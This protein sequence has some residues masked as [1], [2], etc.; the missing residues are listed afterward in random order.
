M[1]PPIGSTTVDPPLGSRTRVNP[2][3]GPRAYRRNDE[4]YFFGRSEEVDELT[5]LVLSSSATLLYAPSGAGKSSLLQAGIT[6]H[7]EHKFG[8]VVLPTV[9]LGAAVHADTA[10]GT[11][12]R[13]IRTVC[14]AVTEAGRTVPDDIA[15]A[16]LVHR[17]G[18]SG[19]VLLILDQ[20]EAIFTDSSLWQERDDFFV[21][22]TRALEQNTWLR[23]IIGLRSDYLAELV[24]HE[25]NLPANLVVRYQLEKLTAQQAADAVE[26]AFAASGMRLA[27]ADLRTIIAALLKDDQDESGAHAAVGLYVNTIQLQVVCRRMWEELQDGYRGTTPALTSTSF[28]VRSAM[29][30]FVD[31]AI[32]EVVKDSKGDEA[33]IRWWLGS[34]L[35]TPAGRRA[36]ALV[37]EQGS[38]VGLPTAIVHALEEVRLIQLEQRNGLRLA[39]L[40]HDSMTKGVRASNDAWLRSRHRRRKQTVVVLSALLLALLAA[41]PLLQVG[42]PKLIAGPL[43]SDKVGGGD[44]VLTFTGGSGAAAVDVEINGKPGSGTATLKVVDL[45]ADVGNAKLVEK[46]FRPTPDRNANTVAVLTSVGHPYAAVLSAPGADYK[47]TVS[48]VPTVAVGEMSAPV[49]LG[50][51]IAVPLVPGQRELITV[52]KL[53]GVDGVVPIQADYAKGWALVEGPPDPRSPSIAVLR[54]DPDSIDPLRPSVLLRTIVERPTEGSGSPPTPV[55]VDPFG[56]VSL[57]TTTGTRAVGAQVN[58]DRPVNA[59]LVVSNSDSPSTSTWTTVGA[60][61]AVLPLNALSTHFINTSQ[62]LLDGPDKSGAKCTVAVRAFPSSVVTRLGNQDLPVPGPSSAAAFAI[63]QERDAVLIMNSTDQVDASLDCASP[64]E[65]TKGPKL[66]AFIPAGTSCDLWLVNKGSSTGPR[67]V[68][69][70]IATLSD[71]GGR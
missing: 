1:T 48:T 47:L 9:H 68:P 55:G 8:F 44:A 42:G 28:S 5:A 65:L 54:L 11:A 16:A 43:T 10:K 41:F 69:V 71:D 17:R 38:S 18:A 67:T 62:L 19:R 12:N 63:K 37:D 7:L 20:F 21:A 14:E 24:P 6:P 26:S 64:V 70:W 25:R 60:K 3:P 22:L 50:S 30:Q 53:S 13:F 59:Q 23:A 31:D 66:T 33:A 39:E 35:I 4:E 45:Q 40:T 34:Q 32:S 15:E 29:S 52:N 51:R 56:S 27:D 58:C 49:V 46:T 2:F 61:I 36:F 57:V